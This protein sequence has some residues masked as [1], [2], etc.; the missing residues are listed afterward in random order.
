GA[1]ALFAG[2]FAAAATASTHGKRIVSVT[3]MVLL[4]VVPLTAA[5]IYRNNELITEGLSYLPLSSPVVM[6]VRLYTGGVDWWEPLAAVGG[7]IDAVWIVLAICG[8]IYSRA[9]GKALNATSR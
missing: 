7:M 6:P 2:M 8:S 3:I 5:A 4:L 1:L 9:T